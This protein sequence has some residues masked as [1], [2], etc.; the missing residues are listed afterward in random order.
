MKSAVS[1]RR[2][3]RAPEG[4][5]SPPRRPRPKGPPPI[6]RK[7][8]ERALQRLAEEADRVSPTGPYYPF[9]PPIADED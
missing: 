6:T 2:V 7:V 3:R 1:R 4:R 5:A 9:G 8:I